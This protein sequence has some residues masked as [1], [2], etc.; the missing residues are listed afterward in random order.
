MKSNEAKPRRSVPTASG[1]NRRRL[2]TAQRDAV[3]LVRRGLNKMAR[4]GGVDGVDGVYFEWALISLLAKDWYGIVMPGVDRA[5]PDLLKRVEEIRA[6][7]QKRYADWEEQRKN[8]PPP[9]APEEAEIR[10]ACADAFMSLW[11]M[12]TSNPTEVKR[13]AELVLAATSVTEAA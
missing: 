6:A 12:R 8:P 3:V 1:G 2:T 10:A 7:E 5:T 13:L 4:S 9:E 11:R